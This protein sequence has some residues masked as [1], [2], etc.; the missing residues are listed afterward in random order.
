M[1]FTDA[2]DAILGWEPIDGDNEELGESDPW[3]ALQQQIYTS[4]NLK[5]LFE[6]VLV[7]R[8]SIGPWVESVVS[9]VDDLD[10]Q[11][12]QD[13]EEFQKHFYRLTETYQMMKSDSE[14][15]LG[16]E[17][18][19]VMEMIKDVEVL[20]AKLEYE[21]N[22]LVSKVQD[23]EEGVAQFER[24]VDSLEFRTEQLEKHLSTETWA[25]WLVRSITGIGTPPNRPSSVAS[26]KTVNENGAS[27]KSVAVDGTNK[28][29]N[30]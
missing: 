12:G 28:K 25:H 3:A 19:H 27:M 29:N 1:S 7:L 4:E 2:E 11:A 6:D 24:E 17:R 10:E 5:K 8:D 14:D 26:V 21:I 16:N 22:A 23:V 20:G 18:A 15:T 30:G 13:Q 9:N